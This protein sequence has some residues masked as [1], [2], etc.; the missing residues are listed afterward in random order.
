MLATM[1]RSVLALFI[2]IF[3][4]VN[5]L[6]A[7][8]NKTP[9]KELVQY[10]LD[11]KKSGLNE[12][13]IQQNA[14]KAGWPAADVNDTIAYLH[15]SPKQG[16][17]E[18]PGA[19]TELPTNPP[20]AAPQPANEAPRSEKPAIGATS[21]STPGNPASAA[22][23]TV[24][25]RGVPDDYQIGAGDALHISVWKEPDAS[26]PSVVVRPDG[27]IS[28]PL[29]KEVSVLGLTPP[30]AEKMITEQL[31]KFITGADVT[32]V[33]TQ[34]NSKKIYVVGAVKKEGPIP[35]TYRMSVMQAISES[36]GLTDYA[37][38]KRIYVLRNE[39]GRQF[40]LPF[41][42]DMVLKGEH[43]ELNQTLL[44]GDTLVVPH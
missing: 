38:R 43:M 34:I 8:Q 20:A 2:L 31:T 19:K 13:Q 10:M 21:A 11:A 22:D 42:Y 25:D 35:Y 37:K 44:P 40:R 30:Q 14:T 33:V 5:Q 16:A 28:M 18:Q 9:P 24:P 7:E 23:G 1:F 3:G 27:K 32:V 36:G 17:N 41:D 12:E 6:G 4:I 26:V 39:N 29:L 15:A